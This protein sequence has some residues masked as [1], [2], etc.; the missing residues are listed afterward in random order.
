MLDPIIEYIQ[1][2]LNF[3]SDIPVIL[4]FASI[5]FYGFSMYVPRL[6]LVLSIITAASITLYYPIYFISPAF[7]NF[8]ASLGLIGKQWLIDSNIER[9][10]GIG[11]FIGT[12]V[13]S[14]LLYIFIATIWELKQRRNPIY[15][16][17]LKKEPSHK[18]YK[19]AKSL[20]VDQYSKA[21]LTFFLDKLDM[22]DI[23]FIRNNLAE[24]NHIK[25]AMAWVYIGVPVRRAVT[26]VRIDLQY[27]NQAG[28]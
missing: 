25:A 8:L 26:K 19:M 20:I 4:V 17:K 3:K 6:W 10:V 15:R 18:N 2:H 7:S 14:A 24:E 23:T 21:E 5:I 11:V 1:S 16:L 22:T 13:I 9:N 12:I 28:A 27:L